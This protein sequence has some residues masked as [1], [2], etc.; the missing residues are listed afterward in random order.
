MPPLCLAR[1]GGNGLARAV[2][3][4]RGMS[5]HTIINFAALV[6]VVLGSACGEEPQP[7]VDSITRAGVFEAGARWLKDDLV[8]CWEADALAVDPMDE[9]TSKKRALGRRITQQVIHETWDSVSRI[10][11]QGRRCPGRPAVRGQSRCS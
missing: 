4:P 10:N 3:C 11:L 7:I 2:L 5:R 9:T 8:V 1:A 6:P